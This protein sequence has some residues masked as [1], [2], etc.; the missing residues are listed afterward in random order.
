MAS[1]LLAVPDLR[2]VLDQIGDLNP[3]WIAVAVGLEIASSASFVVIFRLF[4][5]SV[6]ARTARQLA[7][8][9]MASGALLPGGGAGGLAVGGWLLHLNGMSL[10]RIVQR[11]SGLFFLTSALNV[12]V[13]ASAGLLLVTGIA[14][15]PHDLLLTGLP[16]V[17]A[18]GAAAAVLAVPRLVQRRRDADHWLS[19]LAAG[20]VDARR[21]L[22]RPSWRLAGAA[23]WLGFDIAVLWATFRA[24]GHAP[25][26][27]ALVLAYMIGYLANA[28]PVPAGIGVLDA[29]LAGTLVAYGANA[30]TA[31]A[32]VLVYHAVALWVPGIG[33][34]IAY[35]LLRGR[36]VAPERQSPTPALRAPGRFG[37]ARRARF[38]RNSA[39]D[40]AV[41][42]SRGLR[43]A[44]SSGVST[45]SPPISSTQYAPDS[46]R[47]LTASTRSVPANSRPAPSA[48]A[49]PGGTASER[50][51]SR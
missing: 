49:Y 45:A 40:N 42:A 1:L 32:A 34:S 51:D 47:A 4:F 7:W 12:A 48:T 29:G 23:G 24:V 16:I 11:S 14:G 37:R 6:P 15:G 33:G 9:E 35:G 18:A 22:T 39:I 30:T 36:L 5:D 25:P 28:I 26:A 50:T 27:A 20:I 44:S 17:A 3:A 46:G 10:R 2:K 21:A 31:A 43:R 19:H 8:T 38:S 41:V 13:V